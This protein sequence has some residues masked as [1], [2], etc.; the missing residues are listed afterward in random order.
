MCAATGTLRLLGYEPEADDAL[1]QPAT[2]VCDFSPGR[3]AA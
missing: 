1:P 2:Q 3:L